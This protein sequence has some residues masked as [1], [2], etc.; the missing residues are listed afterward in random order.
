MSRRRQHH[1]AQLQVPQYRA[2]HPSQAD[3][4]KD[5]SVLLQYVVH[6]SLIPAEDKGPSACEAGDHEERIEM[7]ACCTGDH[8]RRGPTCDCTS[9]NPLTL[10]PLSGT[11]RG[12]LRDRIQ[13]LPRPSRSRMDSRLSNPIG[14]SNNLSLRMMFFPEQH[15]VTV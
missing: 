4:A 1:L 14:C 12:P 6:T 7:G 3:N 11:R 15:V 8:V 10:T 9:G 5:T 2:H 13:R